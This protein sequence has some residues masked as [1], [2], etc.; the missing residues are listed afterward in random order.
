MTI[1]GQKRDQF[2]HE[3]ALLGPTKGPYDPEMGQ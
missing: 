3:I 1:G 2:A